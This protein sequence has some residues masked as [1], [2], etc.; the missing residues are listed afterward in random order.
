MIN[1]RYILKKKL[2]EGRSKVYSVI[3]SEFPE[4]EI[5][6]KILSPRCSTGRKNAFR[7]EYFT[8]KKLDHPNLI[9]AYD[10]GMVLTADDNDEEIETGSLFITLERFDS[11]ELLDY[12]SLAEEYKLVEIVK[13]ICSVLFYLHQ[14]NY[15][16]YDLKPQN[17]LVSSVKD[18]PVIKIIDLGFARYILSEY[19]QSIRGTAEYIAPELLKKESHDHSIDLYSLGIILYRIIYDRFP[20]SAKSELD[21]YKAHVDSNFGFPETVYSINFLMLLKN[22]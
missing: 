13:Q 7:Q 4:K 18:Q 17:I 22:C 9:K 19:D 11:V 5:A 8:L 15:I 12:P 10:L 1:Q 21:I 14:S 20:F 3:D 6:M 16:Y 2:G